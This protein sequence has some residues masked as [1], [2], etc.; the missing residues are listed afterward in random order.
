MKRKAKGWEKPD[1]K[2]P[3]WKGFFVGIMG[4]MLSQLNR[5]K[6]K[7]DFE[8]TLENGK[9]V[10]GALATMKYWKIDPAKYP[11]RGYTSTDVKIAFV[12]SLKMSKKAVVRNR[13]KRQM[14]EV[15]RLLLKDRSIPAGYFIIFFAKKEMIEQHFT[16]ISQDVHGLLRRARLLKN[17]DWA[18]SLAAESSGV[19]PHTTKS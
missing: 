14:R 19:E 15:V 1:N 16:D 3:C 7:R 18:G 12:V 9:F 11:K 6:K 2:T 4:I 5:L 10:G 8:I 17:T 13:L